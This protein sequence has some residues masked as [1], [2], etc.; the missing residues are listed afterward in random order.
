[1]KEYKK[2]GY[3]LTYF[4]SGSFSEFR[5]DVETIKKARGLNY[6]IFNIQSS[7]FHWNGV[8][9]TLVGVSPEKFL[10]II[11]GADLIITDSFH[12]TVFSLLF[13]VDCKMKLDT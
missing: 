11:N 5:D 9:E 7:N 1:M 3:I 8:D 4:V 12:G 6:P 13:Q 2:T 10:G